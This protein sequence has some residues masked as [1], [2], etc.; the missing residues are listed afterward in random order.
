MPPLKQCR[1]LPM[2]YGYASDKKLKC[3]QI[4]AICENGVAAI[5]TTHGFMNGVMQEANKEIKSKNIGKVNET[6]PFTQACKD[7]KSAWNKKIDSNYRETVEEL[8]DLPLLPMLAH[9]YKTRKHDIKWPCFIQP[10]LNGVRCLATKKSND[11]IVYISR[12]GKKWE[13]LDY[14]TP[15]LLPLMEIGDTLDGEIFNPD[16][17]F[18]EITKR[19]KRVKTSRFNISSDPLEYHIFDIVDQHRTFADRFGSFILRYAVYCKDSTVATD[20]KNPVVIVPT[21]EVLDEDHM[22]NHHKAWTQQGYEGTMLRNLTGL[23]V[24][25]NRSKDLQKHKDFMDAEFQIVGGHEGT[26]RDKGTVIFICINADGQR[27]NV[28]PKGSLADRSHW[29]NVL[30]ELIGCQL[31]VKF[32]NYSDDGIPIFPVGLNIRDYE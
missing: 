12:K 8:D 16:L 2:L 20:K 6:T 31:T 4:Q 26:G 17:T 27:F 9:P 32:Q 10:K 5:H 30:G 18:Q 24:A 13:T 22:L 28:R 29:W 14:M 11:D 23:Y 25:D 3:W 7:A 15:Y 21:I 19:V 1:T